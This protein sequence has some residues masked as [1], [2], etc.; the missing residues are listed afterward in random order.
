MDFF[1]DLQ[2]PELQEDL[3]NHTVNAYILLS[4]KKKFGVPFNVCSGKGITIADYVK[5]A[6]SI[7][8]LNVEIF[9]DPKRLRP[10]EVPLLI[11][12]NKKIFSETGWRP[13]RS[14]VD[15][16]K[17]GVKYFKEHPEQLGIEAH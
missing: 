6:T 7:F 2:L 12:K 13:T 15:I 8:N 5:L 14:I 9:V 1:L 4:E 17:D 10:S 11:G 16:I 3:L